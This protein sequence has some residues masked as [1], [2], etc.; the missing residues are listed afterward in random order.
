M[1][2]VKARSIF[3]GCPLVISFMSEHLPAPGPEFWPSS[4][5]RGHSAPGES[6]LPTFWGARL[7]NLRKVWASVFPARRS[8]IAIGKWFV[9]GLVQK[10]PQRFPT[11]LNY[12][13]CNRPTAGG[14]VSVKRD[15]F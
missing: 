1:S 5:G 6:L 15:D 13:S 14:F 8:S 7:R 11:D 2:G 10:L 12:A 3:L 4:G 9:T